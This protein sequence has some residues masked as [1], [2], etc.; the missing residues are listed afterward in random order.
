MIYLMAKE[1]MNG[2]MAEY[3][4]VPGLGGKWKAMEFLLGLINESTRET[5][6]KTIKQGKEP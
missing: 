4:K 2:L 5:T 1:N 3:T 6:F